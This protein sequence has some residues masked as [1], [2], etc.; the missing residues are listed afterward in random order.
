MAD[1]TLG[2]TIWNLLLA[3]LNATLILLAVC[4]W[5]AWSITSSVERITTQV[6][7]TLSL[8]RPLRS[9]VE[10]L[11]GDIQDL[12][13]EVASLRNLEFTGSGA[14][15]DVSQSID[16]LTGQIADLNATIESIDIDTDA[17]I[18]KA[19]RATFDELAERVLGLIPQLQKP[20]PEA[21]AG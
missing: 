10:G 3:L 5:F 1:R 12:R 8:V 19:V 11:R 13:T 16:D 6:N 14:V 18:E 21:E 2:R 4:L 7:E 15:S 9:E 17:L 20:A